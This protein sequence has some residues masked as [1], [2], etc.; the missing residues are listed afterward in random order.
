MSSAPVPE[1][2][3]L[4]GLA[5]LKDWPTCAQCNRRVAMWVW[6]D[7][8]F[9][10]RRTQVVRCHGAE[11]KREV[12]TRDLQVATDPAALLASFSAAFRDLEGGE[13]R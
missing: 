7:D 4:P 13:P 3:L 6:W 9:L 1:V 11:E 10:E 2:A 8:L 5:P 12:T